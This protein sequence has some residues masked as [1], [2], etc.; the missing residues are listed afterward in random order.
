MLSFKF[1][2]ALP[3]MEPD[4]QGFLKKYDPAAKRWVE[5]SSKTRQGM[6]LIFIRE[7]GGYSQAEIKGRR[8]HASNTPYPLLLTTPDL[9]LTTSNLPIAIHSYDKLRQTATNYDNMLLFSI[10]HKYHLYI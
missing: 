9:L 8:D 7:H 2:A 10:L 6:T 4:K 3:T 1:Q 5:I